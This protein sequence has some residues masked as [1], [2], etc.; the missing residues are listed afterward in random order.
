MKEKF[1][2]DEYDVSVWEI[3]DDPVLFGE[4]IRSTEDEL[5][6][7]LGWKFD[8]Y[9]KLMLLDESTNVSVC[10][11][12]A[13]GKTVS[14]ETKII[15][16]AVRNKYAKAS[17]NEILLV[18]QNKAQ[19]EP[20][21]LRLTQFFRRHPFLKYFI[22]RN[23]INFSNHEIRLLNGAM[24]RCRIVG[25]SADSNVI[26][27][28]V[29]C[30]LVDEAQVFSYAAWNSLLQC[31]NSWDEGNQIWVS[32]VPNGLREKNVLYEVDQQDD[33]FSRHRVSRL[34]SSRY[35]KEQYHRDLRQYGGENGDDFVHLVKGEH[36]SPAFSVFDRR[37]M[38][39]EDYKVVI[40]TINNITLKNVDG[41]FNEILPAPEPPNNYDMI[42]CGIDAGFS[43]DPTIISILYR[44]H[45]VW[46]FFARYELRR[47][48]YPTQAKIINWLDTAYKFNMLTLDAGHSG[49]A[50]GQMLTE[51]E[52]Y[53]NKKFSERLT[54]VDFQGGVIVD[55]DEDNKEVKDR[56]RKFTIQTLQTWAQSDP[57]IIAF[58]S[59]D[60]DVV[61]EL[62]RVGFTRDMLGEP[63]FFVYSPNGGQKGE[64]HILASILTWVYG[65]YIKAYSPTPKGAGRYSDLAKS[66]AKVVHLR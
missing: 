50:L 36:G 57:K 16:N 10:T 4:F 63:K 54:M 26:G 1:N 40:G 65:Y 25:S 55:Y 33:S 37:S 6:E 2:P 32:G 12:R 48:N 46:R 21:F 35:T 52:E 43:N 9:Q 49:L 13:T 31:L 42:A 41:K 8:N 61:N 11:G 29:P 51:M 23:S 7:N 17:S 56:V 24:V 19:L 45:N 59:E 14:M 15:H 60:E 34:E 27:M 38:M 22:D 20:V 58:S 44:R 62:E 66:T 53:K 47:I 30:I 18:V 3:I 39:I 28:H 5:K 64:D